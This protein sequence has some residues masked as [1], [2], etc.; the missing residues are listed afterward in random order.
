[1]DAPYYPAAVVVETCRSTD[2]RIKR[3]SS[4]PNTG[5]QVYVHMTRSL[6]VQGWT[7]ESKLAQSGQF[8]LDATKSNRRAAVLIADRAIIEPGDGQTRITVLVTP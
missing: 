6:E 7:I 4:A 3:V 8:A 1:M 5:E 2:G